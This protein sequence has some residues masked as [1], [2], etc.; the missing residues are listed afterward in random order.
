MTPNSPDSFRSKAVAFEPSCNA[1]CSGAILT[2]SEGRVA[3]SKQA[4]WHGSV[5][6]PQVSVDRMKAIAAERGSTFTDVVREAVR[7]G[8]RSIDRQERRAS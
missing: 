8:L 2:A 6:I 5:S 3:Q 7:I 1:Y 4:L